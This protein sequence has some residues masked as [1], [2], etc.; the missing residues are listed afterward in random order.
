MEFQ[1]FSWDAR[2]DENGKYIIR[3]FGR[4]ED[5]KSVHVATHFQPYFFVKGKMYQKPFVKAK[6]LWGFQD[7]KEHFFTKLDFDSLEEFREEQ[8]KYRSGLY[9]ANIDPM[10]RFM[11]RTDIKSTGWVKV[12]ENCRDA[13][14]SSCD[15]D[16]WVEDRKSHV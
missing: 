6:D 4:T 13:L 1:V 7:L 12:P 3:M 14:M 10:L 15:I 9:E 16:L 5:G 8:R 2:D 11:H